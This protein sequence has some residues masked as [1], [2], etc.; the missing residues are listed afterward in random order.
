MDNRRT[1]KE[2]DIRDRPTTRNQVS[3]GSLMKSRWAYINVHGGTDEDARG[4]EFF[5]NFKVNVAG[6]KI[7][8]ENIKRLSSM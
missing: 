4:V 8:V 5:L 3:Q 2:S 7:P 6:S 1:T